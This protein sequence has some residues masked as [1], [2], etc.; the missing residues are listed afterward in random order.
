V[1]AALGA[2]RRRALVGMKILQLVASVAEE[3]SG[4]S[5]SVPSLAR[6]LGRHGE[7][8]QL[9]SLLGDELGASTGFAHRVF[10]RARHLRRLWRSPALLG[11][12]RGAARDADLLHSHGLWAMPNV[13]PGWV[14]RAASVPLVISPRGTL[15]P[16]ALNHSKWRK[17][18]FWA[19]A[20]GRVVAAAAC[21]HATAESE[22]REL[23][24]L[25]LRQPICV[26]PNGVDVAALEAG[27]H[28][29]AP[30]TILYVGRL[31]VK[32]G[33]DLLLRAWA[34][35]APSLPGWRLRIVG[36][37]DGGYEA[38]LRRLAASLAAPRVTF[39]GAVYGA[40]KQALYREASLHVLASHSEN[41]GMTVAE[42]LA[43]G[44]PVITTRGTPWSG[45]VSEGC[46][47]WIDIG[48]E[49]LVVALR[50]ATSVGPEALRERGARG[51]RW[52]LRDFSWDRAARDM[53][54][55]YRWL[56]FG[57]EPPGSIR[58]G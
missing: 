55:V 56:L 16:W 5:Y 53:A 32:K 31:H 22:Y 39:E 51:R 57:G 18:A 50:E 26:I 46:G 10:P 54:A 13:Y 30:P 40:D 12:L 48:V 28:A 9:M 2:L 47:W 35:V 38:P 25:G 3:A 17:K 4:P 41:F 19:L 1:G 49:P 37:D 23:R 27:A 33:I 8:V 58:L 42:A 14:A 45:L 52:M 36:P 21:L 44:T 34:I 29:P 43:N 11:A 7:D 6:A 24:G 20:Q 15:S